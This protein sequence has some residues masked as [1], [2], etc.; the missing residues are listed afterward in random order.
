[1]EANMRRGRT[2]NGGL[3]VLAAVSACAVEAQVPVQES[4][5]AA[6]KIVEFKTDST[7]DTVTVT[8]VDADGNTVGTMTL[9]RGHFT[10]SPEY[11]RDDGQN[12]VD[13]RKLS[14]V[15]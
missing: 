4:G 14:V 11:A 5:N 7:A 1:M 2:R 3:A 12:E 10:L 9:F 15:V 8:G 6:L 13:G